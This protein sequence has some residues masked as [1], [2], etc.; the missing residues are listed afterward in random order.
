[1][2]NLQTSMSRLS[3]F[4]ITICIILLPVLAVFQTSML[5][6]LNEKEK[7]NMQAVLEAGANQF[8]IQLDSELSPIYRAIELM[9]YPKAKKSL[10]ERLGNSWQTITHKADTSLVKTI[11]RIIWNSQSGD[12]L[13]ESY[14]TVKGVLKKSNLPVD[15][16]PY[17]QSK[18][19]EKMIPIY[20][21]GA[22]AFDEVNKIPLL[23]NLQ[24]VEFDNNNGQWTKKVHWIVVTLNKDVLLSKIHTFYKG[25]IKQG[26]EFESY[27][28]IVSVHKPEKI[29]Y[30]SG[31]DEP[32]ISFHHPDV[33]TGIFRLHTQVIVMMDYQPKPLIEV[34]GILTDD[35]NSALDPEQ[36]TDK[37]GKIHNEWELL[38]KHRA[39]SLDN[40]LKVAKTKNLSIS[41]GILLILA[42]AILFLILSANRSKKLAD[43][44]MLFVTGISHELKT[45]LAVIN[46][47]GENMADAIVNQPEKIIAYGKLLMNETGKLQ[48]MIENLLHFSRISKSSHI[49]TLENLD[50]ET[51]ILKSLKSVSTEAEKK[52]LAF[53]NQTGKSLPPVKGD[54]H[55]LFL[56]FRN[57]LDNAVKYSFS[58]SDI[59]LTVE[60]I[61][62]NNVLQI[63]VSNQGP[64]LGVSERHQIF[65]PFFRGKAAVTKQ[66]RGSGIGL[67]LVKEIIEAHNGT[68][69]F[70]CRNNDFC[71]FRITLPA[72]ENE[73]QE[74]L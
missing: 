54:P 22:I 70:I 25:L 6:Q 41:F 45:P 42:L 44:Q 38:L 49:G 9:S 34:N 55:A 72:C 1:M 15:L 2:R 48:N 61:K 8:A 68:I 46:S 7:E 74:S 51:V 71:E 24:K 19:S 64:E 13:T 26:R 23:I 29:F 16:V 21:Y 4:V 56:V 65:N 60:N 57:L 66:V 12:V 31:M 33:R 37:T 63:S 10:E 20:N 67:A 27:I 62:A 28:Q 40:V 35:I 14:N 30:N 69:Q 32:N 59:H 52:K 17:I 43:Q 18:S 36:F 39:G 11:Y 5:N 73:T 3:W 58:G 53:I 50:I 47:A